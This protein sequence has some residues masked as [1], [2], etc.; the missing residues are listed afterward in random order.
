MSTPVE[1][2]IV[3]TN[4]ENRVEISNKRKEKKKAARKEKIAMKKE[5]AKRVNKVDVNKSG[6]YNT[7]AEYQPSKNRQLLILFLFLKELRVIICTKVF[8][9]NK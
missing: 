8:S 6:A 1:I 5:L 3:N 2:P 4:E 9:I 7:K